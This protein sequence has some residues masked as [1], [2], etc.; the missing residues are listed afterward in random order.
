MTRNLGLVCLCPLHERNIITVAA[1]SVYF[2]KIGLES[3]YVGNY[4]YYVIH[5]AGYRACAHSL[6]LY[7][8]KLI[9]QFLKK[10]SLLGFVLRN[11]TTVH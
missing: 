10:I 2:I 8:A 4:N 11:S 3:Y 1:E 5:S 9:L 6:E 7:K